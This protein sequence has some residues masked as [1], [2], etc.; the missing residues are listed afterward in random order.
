MEKTMDHRAAFKNAI[1]H[2][3]KAGYFEALAQGITATEY[4]QAV[5]EALDELGEKKAVPTHA[6]D[7][8]FKDEELPPP[9][10][11][12]EPQSSSDEWD[13]PD[14]GWIKRVQVPPNK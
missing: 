12:E 4:R 10:D 1:K 5:T 6:S 9:T 7:G 11:F 13:N 2:Q 3:I 8:T 14:P